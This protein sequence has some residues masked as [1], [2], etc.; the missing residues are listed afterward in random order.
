MADSPG[1][2]PPPEPKRSPGENWALALVAGLALVCLSLLTVALVLIL[3]K[4]SLIQVNPVFNARATDAP[5]ETPAA[6][7][8][9]RFGGGTPPAPV[10]RGF[11]YGD[12]PN[13]ALP[14]E[15]L[16]PLIVDMAA[17]IGHGTGIL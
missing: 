17:V 7:A 9:D 6:A 3:G 1:G 13:V 16:T 10:Q 5:A 15:A 4:G 2:S 14:V 8:P 11:S 12:G